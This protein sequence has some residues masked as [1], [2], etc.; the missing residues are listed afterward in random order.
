MQNMGKGDKEKGKEG[1]G[2]TTE[3][4]AGLWNIGWSEKIVTGCSSMLIC[5]FS[6]R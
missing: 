5:G 1:G 6:T 3:N 2:N 4:V